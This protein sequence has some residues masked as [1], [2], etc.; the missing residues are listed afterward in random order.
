M[1]SLFRLLVVSMCAALF[2]C[3]A[4]MVPASND[5]ESKLGWATVLLREQNRPL[6]AE[7]LIREAIV[8]YQTHNDDLGLA[9]AYREYGIFFRSGS[10]ENYADVYRKDGFLDKTASFDQRLD[11][12]IEYLAKS[13]GL[14][15]KLQMYERVGNLDLN[16]E[17]VYEEKNDSKLACQALDR[18]LANYAKFMAANPGAKIVFTGKYKDKSFRE[19]IADEKTQS[20][21]T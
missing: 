14:F 2:G 12:S 8:I 16:L 21:C 15:E 11:K 10:V 9:K 3:A 19:V 17:S 1:T 6:P 5:P 20:K 7:R 4:A 13:R 18:S